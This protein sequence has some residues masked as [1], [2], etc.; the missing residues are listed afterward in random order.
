MSDT[1]KVALMIGRR[2]TDDLDSNQQKQLVSKDSRHCVV[3]EDLIQYNM[4]NIVVAAVYQAS[5]FAGY[6]IGGKSKDIVRSTSACVA[7]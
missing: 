2:D 7:C 6:S 3:Y 5:C 4:D 1:E